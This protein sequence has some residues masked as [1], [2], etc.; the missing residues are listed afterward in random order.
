MSFNKKEIFSDEEEIVRDGLGMIEGIIACTK[1]IKSIDP[2][3][4]KLARIYSETRR[5]GAIDNA[6]LAARLGALSTLLHCYLTREMKD[7]VDEAL[8]KLVPSQ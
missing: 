8:R 4:F 6:L 7:K 1:G 2:L 3:S 5:A